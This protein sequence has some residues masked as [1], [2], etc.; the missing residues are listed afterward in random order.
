[1]LVSMLPAIH[2]HDFQWPIKP[3]G[4]DPLLL[5]SI[6][7]KCTHPDSLD[8]GPP[9]ADIYSLCYR[10]VCSRGDHAEPLNKEL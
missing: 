7:P 9:G 4:H 10:N 8:A 3:D 6:T 5:H 1:M 2:I